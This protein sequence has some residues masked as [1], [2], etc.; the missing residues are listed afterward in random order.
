MLKIFPY[1]LPPRQLYGTQKN[2]CVLL[3][4]LVL[5]NYKK[6]EVVISHFLTDYERKMTKTC[7]D[8]QVPAKL[9]WMNHPG[10]GN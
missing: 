3:F 10:T 4:C 9:K 1:S 5:L 8:C 7:S 6:N 2:V